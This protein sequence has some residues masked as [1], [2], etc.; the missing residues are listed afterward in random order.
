LS[1]ADFVIGF[2]FFAGTVGLS[3]YSGTVVVVRRLPELRGAPLAVA[4][5]TS[6]LAAICL[7]NLVPGLLGVLSR[8]TAVAVAA[9]LALAAARCPRVAAP[10]VYPT[11]PRA[12]AVESAWSQ[13]IAIFLVLGTAIWFLAAVLTSIS[14]PIVGA[15]ATNFHLPTVASWI[16][17]KSIWEPQQFL[18]LQAQAF[19]PNSG[20]LTELAAVLPWRSP[21]L[22][23]LVSAPMLPLAALAVYAAGREVSAT[24][25]TA[26]VVAVALAAIPITLVTTVDRLTPDPFMLATL[27]A[28]VL[29]LLR[30]VRTR[31]TGELLLAATGLGLAFGSR[32]HA[33]STV[34]LVLVVWGVFTVRPRRAP[35]GLREAGILAGATLAVGGIW[36]LRNLIITG[37][38]TFP[39]SISPL[40]LTLF[41]AP[42]DPL[43]AEVG[44]S[45][46]HYL[47]D[48]SV[49][50]EFAYPSFRDYLG[51]AGAVVGLLGIFGGGALALRERRR[52]HALDP[53]VLALSLAAA[54]AAIAYLFTPYSALGTEGAPLGIGV[55]TR[56]LVPALVLAAPAGALVL[57][58]AGRATE[59]VLLAFVPATVYSLAKASDLGVEIGRGPLVLAAIAVGL[60]ITV[61]VYVRRQ[62]IAMPR[63]T[64]PAA[65]GAA[66]L[67]FLGTAV[68]LLALERRFPDAPYAGQE[69]A[70]DQMLESDRPLRVG[71]AGA[72]DPAGLQPPLAAFGSDLRN[73][74]EYIGNDSSHLLSPCRTEGEFQARLEQL[75]PD[76]VILGLSSVHSDPTELAR[77]LQESG[78]VESASSERLAA[79]L[80]ASAG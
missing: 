26:A 36:L 74:V 67:A 13:R 75:S 44:F 10:A 12:G 56:Y 29:F 65:I 17:E 11:Y 50:R 3:A 1:T 46:S 34:A 7:V 30:Y 8:G 40:G 62:S 22:V 70:V 80:P 43:R 32:W 9:L 55:N 76:V 68:M 5:G 38:P 78:Y 52:G 31:N 58:R 48:W 54:L 41:D 23:H 57:T 53:R 18:P 27:G 66:M 15:D 16:Q 45:I 79:Y 6:V 71:L 19:Y 24:R 63:W 33:V 51:I 2:L 72:W 73:S 20:N 42:G 14:D 69:P 4:L 77:W 47:S 37:D 39:A 49:L 35:T 60:L 59:W 64:S 61:L 21:F 25:S 28:G